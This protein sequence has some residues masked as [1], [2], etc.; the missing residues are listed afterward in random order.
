[1]GR[2]TSEPMPPPSGRKPADHRVAGG[3]RHPELLDLGDAL[4]RAAA[5]ERL[6][7][8][9]DPEIALHPE[10]EE[11]AAADPLDHHR[12]KRVGHRPEIAARAGLAHLP[13]ALVRR[14]AL[15]FDPLDKGQSAIALDPPA[16][17]RVRAIGLV[18]HDL[19]GPDTLGPSFEKAKRIRGFRRCRHRGDKQGRGQEQGVR[20]HEQHPTRGC[21]FGCASLGSGGFQP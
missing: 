9:L 17:E 13:A 7:P 8:L 21:R 1:M 19:R 12:P 5:V 20:T 4:R 16:A 6:Q 11:I 14:L 15:I 2:R 3:D 18:E 10:A